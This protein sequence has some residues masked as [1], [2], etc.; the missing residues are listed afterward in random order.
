MNN[1]LT[2][3]VFQTET[4]FCYTLMMLIDL[5]KRI[6]PYGAVNPECMASTCTTHASLHKVNLVCVVYIMFRCLYA[7][8][9]CLYYIYIACL[10]YVLY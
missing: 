8:Y 2:N 7:V 1:F 9:V 10:Y 3:V 4:L 5:Q 6:W